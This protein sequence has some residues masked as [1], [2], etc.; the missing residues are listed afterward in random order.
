M[1]EAT[2]MDDDAEF[3]QT[4]PYIP[5]R[6]QPPPEILNSGSY[7]SR[8][9]KLDSN[10]I[11]QIPV[12][13]KADKNQ[14]QA[15]FEKFWDAAHRNKIQGHN[16]FKQQLFNAVNCTYPEVCTEEVRPLSPG[17]IELT[18]KGYFIQIKLKFQ[19]SNQK[20]LAK[21]A[22][23]KKSQ[24]HKNVDTYYDEKK[25]LFGVA[26]GNHPSEIDNIAFFRQLHKKMYNKPL[27]RHMVSW[28]GWNLD[29]KNPDFAKY[30]TTLLSTA[31]AIINGVQD[32]YYKPGEDKGCRSLSYT[33]MTKD[34]KHKKGGVHNPITIGQLNPLPDDSDS[35]DTD[36]S[37]DDSSDQNFDQDEADYPVMALN[38]KR[39]AMEC[40]FCGKLGHSIVNCWDKKQEK[41]PHPQGK[42]ALDQKKKANYKKNLKPSGRPTKNPRKGLK[43]GRAKN[44][45]QLNDDTDES[46]SE[47]EKTILSPETEKYLGQAFDMGFLPCPLENDY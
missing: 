40:W 14:I 1:F 5:Q 31:Q 6:D 30:R 46:E 27:V 21:A 10:F 9:E 17:M 16:L 3:L 34:T 47:E 28:T 33:A 41:P 20:D 18:A 45:H 35:S 8:D 42:Y 24:D 19:P 25:K 29:M 12:F 43:K 32:G 2:I 44:I 38:E 26:Y 23:E 37:S 4:L 36:S 13:Q 39:A 11:T 7:V 22:F 15:Y